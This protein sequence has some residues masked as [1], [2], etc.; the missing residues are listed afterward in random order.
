VQK[1]LLLGKP[2]SGKTTLVK[3]VLAVL[4]KISYGGFFTEEIREKDNRIGFKV[5]STD[6]EEGV[7]AHENYKSPY[8]VSKYFVNVLDFERVALRAITQAMKDKDLIVIDEIGK[9]ELFSDRFEHLIEEIFAKGRKKILAT[10]PVSKIPLIEK[11]RNLPDT[12]VIEVTPANRD[13]LV[14]ELIKRLD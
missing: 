1:I 4:S 13:Q 10:I 9:M 11:L 5:V 14:D 3:K 8:R 6:G 7:L 2:K 12:E